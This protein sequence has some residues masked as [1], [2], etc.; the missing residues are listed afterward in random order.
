MNDINIR[1]ISSEALLE[2]LP[3]GPVGECV[4]V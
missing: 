4:H 1:E 3:V 2:V